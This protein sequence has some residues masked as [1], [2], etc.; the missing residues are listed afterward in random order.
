MPEARL[1]P[2]ESAAGFRALEAEFR[3][4]HAPIGATEL[5]LVD[6][7][8][9]IEW[10]RRR[11]ALAERAAH[12][13]ALSDRLGNPKRILE[14]AGVGTAEIQSRLDVAEIAHGGVNDDARDRIRH[15]ADREASERALQV[16]ENGG[17]GVYH[18]AVKALHPDTRD[19]WNE[20]LAGEAPESAA[21]PTAAGLSRFLREQVTAAD[22]DI[23][24]ADAARPAVRIQ[25]WGESLDP[26][27]I[28]RLLMIDARLDRQFE[29]ALSLLIQMQRFRLDGRAT[30]VARLPVT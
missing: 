3:Q 30:K 26:D 5:A 21:E 1:L 6:R 9:W 29:K 7:L 13:A 19:W 23:A 2:W 10:R 17:A 16:L 11:L 14:R 22:A 12:A 28:E 8:V 20:E 18:S 15:E 27:R 24:A 4:D 25:A